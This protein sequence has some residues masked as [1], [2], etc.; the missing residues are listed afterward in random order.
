[1]SAIA[2][3]LRDG[4]ELKSGDPELAWRNWYRGGS[5]TKR[6]DVTFATANA[7]RAAMLGEPLTKIHT[8]ETGYKWITTRRRAMRIPNTPAPDQVS[9]QG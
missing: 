6:G 1:M 7:V 8:G 9:S 5:R 4:L 2:V 3:K